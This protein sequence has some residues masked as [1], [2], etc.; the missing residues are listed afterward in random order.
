METGKARLVS[1]T[2]AVALLR[3]GYTFVDVRSELEFAAGHP[4][5]ATNVPLRHVSGDRLVDNDEFLPVMRKTFK[6][7]ARLIVGCHSGARSRTA[8]NL[9]EA[10]GYAEVAELQN[11]FAGS[12]DAFGRHVAG[13]RDLDLPVELGQPAGRSYAA[14]RARLHARPTERS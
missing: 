14:L 3:A 10:E 12:R 6:K 4:P 1:S 2:R 7:S 8:R 11:G 5:G 9:L 13:W